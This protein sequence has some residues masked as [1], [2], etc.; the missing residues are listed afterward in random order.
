MLFTACFPMGTL[1]LVVEHMRR[2]CSGFHHSEEQHFLLQDIPTTVQ[3]A[4]GRR[5]LPAGVGQ[6]GRR[7]G[8]RAAAQGHVR[9]RAPQGQGA[10]VDCAHGASPFVF[11]QTLHCLCLQGTYI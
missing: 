2:A 11:T 7:E 3:H 8:A 6:R 5:G 10:P 1:A 9:Q 4:G